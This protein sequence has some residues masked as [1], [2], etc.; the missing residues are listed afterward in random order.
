MANGEWCGAHNSGVLDSSP[1]GE[2]PFAPPHDFSG[3]GDDYMEFMRERYRDKSQFAARQQIS[4]VMYRRHSVG[5]TFT[6]IGPYAD[7]VETI[8]SAFAALFTRNRR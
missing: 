3:S 5:A 4:C 6:I 8:I 7:R 1:G 2:G